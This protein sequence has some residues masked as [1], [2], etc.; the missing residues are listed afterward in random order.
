MIKKSCSK[1]H[2]FSLVE[3]MIVIALLTVVL[4]LTTVNLFKPVSKAKIDSTSS[5]LTSLLREAQNK[6]INTERESGITSDE[7]GVHF[8]INKYILFKGATYDPNG[9]DNFEVYTPENL[10]LTP[11]LPCPSPPGECN[12]VVF[13][14][15]SGEVVSFDN[16]KNTV[17]LAENATNKKVLLT[18]N[19][20][21]V[22]DVQ[23]GCP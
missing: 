23:E 1:D 16:S 11:N 8:E 22:V 17:C 3:L 6:A 9:S 5:D 21:G 2:G 18:V 10:T 12:N 7:Y 20:V 4:I 19:F 15:I 14:R 13:K